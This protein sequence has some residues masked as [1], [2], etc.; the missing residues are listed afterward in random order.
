MQQS[1]SASGAGIDWERLG[2]VLDEAMH[3]LSDGD[4]QILLLRFFQGLPFGAI[5]HNLAVS[6]DAARMR[7][8]RAL[9]RLRPLLARREI[10]STTAALGLLLANQP[11]VAVPAHLAA[12]VTGSA[13]AGVAA[14]AGALGFLSAVV[15]S[16]LPLGIAAAAVVVGGTGLTLQQ[17]TLSALRDTT[18]GLQRQIATLAT[19]NTASAKARADADAELAQVRQEHAAETAGLRAEIA[20]LQ[21]SAAP[22]ARTAAS[23]F[24]VPRPDDIRAF[25][26]SPDYLRLKARVMQGQ[27][28]ARYATLFKDLG[29]TSDQLARF[30][31]LLIEKQQAKDVASAAL[32]GRIRGTDG[33]AQAIQSI[34]A[35]QQ[36]ADRQIKEALGDAAYGIYQHYEQ[37]LRERNFVEQFRRSLS[38]TPTPLSDDQASRMIEIVQP[39]TPDGSRGGGFLLSMG[40]S[41]QTGFGGFSAPRAILITDEMVGLARAVLAREQLRILQ[42]IQAQ[43]QAQKE[44]SDLMRPVLMREGLRSESPSP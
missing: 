19:E 11:A 23:P 15:A 41:T 21:K 33:L 7:V 17:R 20:A 35:A 36:P 30:K 5:G 22:A 6:E 26:D 24:P 27:L 16:K 4:R 9:D 3:E 34:A 25:M 37:T 39:R 10:T 8:G 12:S 14:G 2:P 18:A 32:S 43:Q 28:D 1:S 38:Y 42:Q 44:I 29:L 40:V 31:A 13:M